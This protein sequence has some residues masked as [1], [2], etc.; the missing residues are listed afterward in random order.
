MA[1]TYRGVYLVGR[2]LNRCI[3]VVH[4]VNSAGKSTTLR[5]REYISRGIEPEHKSFRGR[6]DFRPTDPKSQSS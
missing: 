3:R 6:E 4:V 5:L 2:K 1:V